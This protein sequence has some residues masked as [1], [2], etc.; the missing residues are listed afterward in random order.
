MIVFLLY[1]FGPFLRG[2]FNEF[3]DGIL[4]DFS[5]AEIVDEGIAEFVFFGDEFGGILM[6][7]ISSSQYL[8]ISSSSK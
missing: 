7:G 6:I 1:S 5:D 4:F 2:R 3:D 8:S